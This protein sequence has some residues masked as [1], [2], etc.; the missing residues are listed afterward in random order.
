MDERDS[1]GRTDAADTITNQ[2]VAEGPLVSSVDSA[3]RGIFLVM[4]DL[5]LFRYAR[6]SALVEQCK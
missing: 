2:K 4:S 6:N 3:E 1:D 5:D